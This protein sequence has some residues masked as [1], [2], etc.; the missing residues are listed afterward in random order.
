MLEGFSSC[1]FIFALASQNVGP[2]EFQSV[3]PLAW[4]GPGEGPAGLTLV[5]ERDASARIS[6]Q[7]KRPWIL[8][9]LVCWSIGISAGAG[10]AGREEDGSSR[11]EYK[12]EGPG[13]K[14]RKS[15]MSGILSS[16]SSSNTTLISPG[17]ILCLC[18]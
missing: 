11:P 7:F 1:S 9:I 12:T 3:K 14:S 6:S 17:S 16:C 10:A 13:G 2:K 5:V 18:W 15:A 8:S 4:P